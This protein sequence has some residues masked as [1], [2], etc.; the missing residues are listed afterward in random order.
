MNMIIYV[1]FLYL[2]STITYG[3]EAGNKVTFATSKPMTEVI[4]DSDLVTVTVQVNDPRSSEAKIHIELATPP[5]PTFTT[6]DF[7]Y[8]ESSKLISSDV[9]LLNGKYSFATVFPI[10]GVYQLNVTIHD[11]LNS[12][13]HTEVITLKVPENPEKV[14]NLAVFIAALATIGTISGLVIGRGKQTALAKYATVLLIG[15]TM[16]IAAAP[17]AIAH[18][19][20]AHKP[21]LHATPQANSVSSNSLTTNLHLDTAE[22]RVGDLADIRGSLTDTTG[23]L[24][25]AI[26]T[27]KFVQLE[28]NQIVFET[29]IPSRTGNFT[30]KGQFF[31]GS[32]HRVELYAVPTN[33]DFVPQDQP[34]KP[35]SLVTAVLAREPPIAAVAKSLILLVGI[36]AVGLGLGIILSSKSQTPQLKVESH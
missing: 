9:Q 23:K 18:G 19:N 5:T 10:R 6:T 25:P 12:N 20:E 14:K 7:P 21:S 27:L 33:S 1:F 4:P 30:W 35:V 32:E 36:V 11:D 2:T 17:K 15:V 34:L 3:A 28:H 31:D 22:P 13:S 8:V 16:Q 24:V 29:S 26:F